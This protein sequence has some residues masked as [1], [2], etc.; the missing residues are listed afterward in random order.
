MKK[1]FRSRC[2]NFLKKVTFSS[3]SVFF[4]SPIYLRNG[5][6]Q[7]PY[8]QQSNFFYLTG[9]NKPHLILVL[10]KEEKNNKIILFNY[11][12]NKKLENQFT[13]SLKK[14]KIIYY[15]CNINFINNIIYKLLKTVSVIYHA[16]NEFYY[17]DNI[18]YILLKNKKLT[19]KII[20]WRPIIN[21]M[22]LFKSN[23]EISIIKK[24]CKICSYAHLR[25]M[26]YCSPGMYEYQL[27][28]E[29][30]HEFACRGI[31]SVAFPTIVGSGNNSCI[32]HYTE[33]TSLMKF[34]DLVLIDAGAEYKGY[35]SDITSTFP[36]NGKF[37]IPQKEIYNI[38]LLSLKT[39]LLLYKPGISIYDVNAKI[40]KIKIMGL[41]KLGILKGN[42]NKLIEKKA[43]LPFF[44]HNLSHWIG[45][46][47]H[48]VGD[49]GLRYN[50]ILKPGMV[51]SIE[52]AIYIPKNYKNIPKQYRG[53]GIRLEDNILITTKGNKNLTSSVVR[54]T[55][56]IENIMYRK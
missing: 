35:A 33:K 15:E 37:N 42:V 50:R 24:S 48:D 46:D 12:F 27:S 32:L 9:I 28:A 55:E 38:V 26:K 49:Y 20:D 30:E 6:V 54:N 11:D 7:Y 53:I 8:R 47:V 41:I 25:A 5:D 2:K 10:I 13:L 22:R 43:Y 23:E 21:E 45:L 51:I 1:L 29:I 52:P 19:R 16:K 18:I 14:E 17:A 3:L 40:L 31:K 56:I 44:M 4:S 36:V 39:A 34:G